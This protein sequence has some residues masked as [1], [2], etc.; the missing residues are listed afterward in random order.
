MSVKA[1]EYI[2]GLLIVLA[3]GATS[4][5]ARE[6]RVVAPEAPLTEAGQKLEARY[7]EQLKTLK[8]EILKPLVTGLPA[9]RNPVRSKS[10]RPLRGGRLIRGM[11]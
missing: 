3:L 6:E 1:M 10:V 4:A 9:D 7:A 2:R 5:G 8:A 11:R